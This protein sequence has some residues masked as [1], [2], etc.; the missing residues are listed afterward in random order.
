MLPR[1]LIGAG[2]GVIAGEILGYVGKCTGGTCPLTRNPLRSAAL[3]AA[4]GA[5]IGASFVGS[6]P[7]VAGEA[8]LESFRAVTNTEEYDR[9]VL[10]ADKP[11]PVDFY[12]TWCGYCR[13]LAPTMDRVADEY[14]GRA[15]FVKV[16][17]DK[18][19]GLA[20]RYGINGLP[21]VLVFRAGSGA[22]LPRI[23]CLRKAQGV[24]TKGAQR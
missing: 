22:H 8:H 3:M 18:S 13:Q 9:H 11:V 2:I 21:T 23:T 1:I 24:N 19:A 17:V 10:Q 14:S 4:A 7:G 6:G 15:D 16:D 5:L 20:R 12:A